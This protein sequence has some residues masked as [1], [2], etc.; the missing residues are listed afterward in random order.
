MKEDSYLKRS[1]DFIKV[2]MEKQR[3]L[4]PN[5]IKSYRGTLSQFLDY[6]IH[7]KGIPILD[8]RIDHVN[9]E[10]VSSYLD[11]LQA[12]RHCSTTT[13][14]Q[15]LMALRSFGK[16]C[17]LSGL[18]YICIQMDMKKVPI[19]KTERKLVDFLS[20]NAMTTLLSMPDMKHHYGMRNGCFMILMYDT[21]A[22]CQEM[23]DIRLSDIK[24]EKESYY[25]NI[26]GKGDKIRAV[27]IMEKTVQHIE[28]YM[29]FYHPESS[30]NADDLLFYTV[31]H[32]EHH[33]MSADTVA[34]F[35]DQY[36]HAAH[37]LNTEVPVH[38]HAHQFRHTRAI[39]LYR[40]GMPLAL[41][42]ELLGHAKIETTRIYAYASPEMQADAINK[43]NH[44][45]NTPDVENELW[46]A[47]EET[48]KRL[49]GLI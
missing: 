41:L 33:P 31:S 28:H 47:D 46:S 3:M 18:E 9:Y 37:K 15:R 39:H 5:T 26:H 36:S 7:E 44:P 12:E 4:S 2:Y 30:R 48:I 43:A 25:I 24:R 16:Y 14:N 8:V 13:R 17:S 19:Q 20:E 22:R 10:N 38:V 1:R 45:Q 32:G 27:P 40:A 42:S 11:W 49:Y 34:R 29:K 23:L 35:I 21:A 6:L